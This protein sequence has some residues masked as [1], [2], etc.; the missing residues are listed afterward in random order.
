[1]RSGPTHH[2]CPAGRRVAS[3]RVD[4]RRSPPAYESQRWR[5]QD[6][7]HMHPCTFHISDTA[8]RHTP[9]SQARTRTG[10][11]SQAQT[12]APRVRRVKCVRVA[13]I[14]QAAPLASGVP[15]SARATL[16]LARPAP[17]GGLV[18]LRA[19]PQRRP[20]HS[21]HRARWVR[22]LRAE[23]PLLSSA[24]PAW[25]ASTK[26]RRAQLR[27]RRATRGCWRTTITRTARRVHLAP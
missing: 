2:G 14:A 9:R 7:I 21:A 13:R 27:A 24:H 10:S 11:A 15:Q 1:M 23:P 6:L 16:R 19:W 25:A 12:S 5:H 18:G 26:T 20:A 8:R 3:S 22:P 4:E 17:Q